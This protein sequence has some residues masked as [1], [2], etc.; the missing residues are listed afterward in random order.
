MYFPHP[1]QT[2][3]QVLFHDLIASRPSVALTYEHDQT[4]SS[5]A[6]PLTRARVGRI[7]GPTYG[8]GEKMVYPG[9]TLGFDGPGKDREDDV[10]SL[11]VM[12]KGEGE[13]ASLSAVMSVIIHVSPVQSHTI[14]SYVLR[15]SKPGIGVI[16]GLADG[17]INVKLGETTVQDILLDLGPPLR[18]YY[19]E[20]DRVEKMW[21]GAG[22]GVNTLDGGLGSCEHIEV[23]RFAM[24]LNPRY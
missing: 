9:I 2:L 20:D 7:L 12:G 6:Q 10:K 8:G 19:K 22:E 18:K 15:P 11:K 1:S 23:F 14:V 13:V 4:L 21:G 16:I 5:N 3:Q 24:E 17:P